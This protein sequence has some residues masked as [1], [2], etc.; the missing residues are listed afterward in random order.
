MLTARDQELDIVVGLAAG[1]VDADPS[2]PSL[3]RCQ[4]RR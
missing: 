4:P 3:T 1:A 2:D